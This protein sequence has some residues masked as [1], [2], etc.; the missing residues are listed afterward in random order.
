MNVE[1]YDV[2]ES[3]HEGKNERE[4]AINAALAQIAL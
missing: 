1:I 4:Q 3:E 2:G